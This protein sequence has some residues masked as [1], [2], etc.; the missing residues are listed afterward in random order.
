MSSWNKTHV[1]LVTLVGANESKG[2][3]VRKAPVLPVLGS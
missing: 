1:L 2:E 3:G